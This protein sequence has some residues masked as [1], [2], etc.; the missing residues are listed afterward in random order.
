MTETTDH[1]TVESEVS[2][3]ETAP[4]ESAA[5]VEVG[6]VKIERGIP[7]PEIHGGRKTGSKHDPVLEAMQPG[8]S[9]FF[10]GE[11]TDRDVNSFLRV[12][13]KRKLMM[14]TR[15]TT[16]GGVQGIRVWRRS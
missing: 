4:V 7:I 5:V 10:S 1:P 13:K 11:T 12:A 16:E 14:S 8:D 6:G 2:E 9:V 3:T 15:K